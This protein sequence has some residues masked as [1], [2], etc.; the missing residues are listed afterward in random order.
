MGC[1]G[2]RLAALC[3]ALA[4]GIGAGP[5]AEPL[6]GDHAAAARWVNIGVLA[7]EGATRC[8]AQ[9]D[10][11]AEYLSQRVA[12]FRFQVVPLGYADVESAVA[13]R[14]V[15]FILTNPGMYVT[16]EPQY[17]IGRIAT[18]KNR[19]GNATAATY[20]TVIFRRADCQAIRCLADLRG[21]RFMAPEENSFGGWLMA[22]RE[23][24]KRGIDPAHDFQAVQFSGTQD[25]VVLAVLRGDV[26]AGAVRTDV[27]ER[28]AAKGTIR[29]GDFRI[30]P[31]YDGPRD[32]D[33]PCL[34][35]TRTYP[36]WPLARLQHTP[37]A[38]AEQVAEQLRRMP[39]EAVAASSAGIAG[40]TYPGDYHEVRQCMEELEAGPFRP[41]RAVTVAAVVKVYWPW[42]LATALAVA[43]MAAAIVV[44]AGLNRRLAMAQ[45]EAEK[46]AGRL[47]KLTRAVEQSPAS[48]VITDRIG[49]VEYVNPG[50]VGTTG[51]SF[52]EALGKNPRML[53]SGVHPPEF[54]RQMWETLSRKEVWRGEICNRKKNGELYWEDATVAPVLGADGM[55]SSFVAVK[56]DITSRRQAE[57][58]LR[59]A[60]EH[61]EEASLAK[62]RFLASMSHELRTPLNGVIGMTELL[63]NTQ[64]DERQR[65]FVEACHSSGE[66]LLALINDI[67]DF[68]KI[69]A[70]K[71]ELDEHEFD[72]ERLVGETVETMA[73]SAQRK[74]L[75]LTGHVA[76]QACRR[77][78]GDSGRLRQILVNLV[79]NA[80][81]F[82][83]A[84]EI[85]VR[86][87]AAE[88]P[89]RPGTLRFEVSDTG[90]GILA[91]RVER[92]FQSFSQADAST[93]RKYGGTGLGLAISKS[94]V[95]LMGGRI[96]VRSQSGHGST[97][98]FTLALQ[99]VAGGDR[100]GPAAASSGSLT[101][102]VERFSPARVLLAED[103][104]VNRL[105]AGEI[106]RAA[107]L[108]CEVVENGRQALQAVEEGH[109]DLVLMDCQ[110]P[111]LDG[112]DATRRIRAMEQA[113]KLPGHLPVIALT[114][115]AIKGDRDRCVEAGMDDYVSKPFEPRTLLQTMGRFLAMQGGKAA[116]AEPL[117]ASPAANVPA[118]IDRDALL[119][120]CMGNLEFAGSLLADFEDDLRSRVDQI[121]GQAQAGDARA[122]AESAHALKGAA[123]IITAESVRELAARIE[124]TG[125]AGD[126][127]EVA[128]LADQ[129]H[130]EAGRLL[131]VL[132][133]LREEMTRS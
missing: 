78:R 112:F 21:K 49:A 44:F 101:A 57:E 125:K 94:L 20:G 129:L 123:A 2:L 22:L 46:A 15:D 12:G 59:A 25:A 76:P 87:A 64:L 111:E 27:L 106:L 31:A 36:E 105:F 84:G 5:A 130:D 71:L 68:S 33:F 47:R 63:R 102:G 122:A 6:A 61:A 113:G 109:F 48:I 37:L 3:F 52:E 121:V 53:Q 114:A 54:Y 42:L 45:R 66:S 118:P 117:P 17:R 9:W 107:G 85:T 34:V 92:L 70:G 91:D 77:V 32:A 39:M 75:Q 23:L 4:V 30:I 99:G 43:G 89:S 80:V 133:G 95:E 28:M 13:A 126:A 74:G 79:G 104:R 35:S 62:S 18:M 19:I 127:R 40:W 96:G 26:Q 128:A 108:E 14:Q 83:E 41:S 65:Q 120:R 131:S 51:Y 93:T 86:V 103:N 82:T 24:R 11:T 72:L 56:I 8:R 50:F 119:A 38:L 67:L 1:L 132:P 60:K 124:A 58:A 55:V 115:N 73:F 116:A 110:M 88:E 100:D 90:I 10:A 81:K 16:L 69:E 29:L 98:W 7:N 97:F